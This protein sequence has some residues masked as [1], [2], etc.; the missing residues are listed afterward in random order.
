MSV[1]LETNCNQINSERCVQHFSKGRWSHH[2]NGFVLEEI[3]PCLAKVCQKTFRLIYSRKRNCIALYLKNYINIVL[4]YTSIDSYKM[5]LEDFLSPSLSLSYKM[6]LE[7][8]PLPSLSLISKIS[9][10]KIDDIKCVQKG[11]SNV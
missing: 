5:L 8:F 2:T 4:R 3:I 9:K 7:D 10:R 6:L 1:P 11:W